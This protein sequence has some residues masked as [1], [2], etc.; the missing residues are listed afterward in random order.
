MEAW[1]SDCCGALGKKVGNENTG[2][3]VTTMI[4]MKETRDEGG[5]IL[6]SV[7]LL[8]PPLLDSKKSAGDGENKAM[9]FISDSAL[10]VCLHPVEVCLNT[11][12]CMVR[13]LDGLIV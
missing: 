5:A 11:E 9:S 13:I 2:F 1:A 12:N 8:L 3:V 6:L 4:R 10:F 7:S